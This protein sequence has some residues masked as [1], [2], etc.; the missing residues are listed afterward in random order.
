MLFNRKYAKKLKSPED[1]LNDIKRVDTIINDVL[2]EM[3]QYPQDSAPLV[4]SEP[5]PWDYLK[6]LCSDFEFFENHS[7]ATPIEP[8]SLIRNIKST[9]I[10]DLKMEVLRQLVS[11][12]SA[13]FFEVYHNFQLTPM[14]LL[15]IFAYPTNNCCPW[16]IKKLTAS[17]ISTHIR[18]L[19]EQDFYY[20]E[21]FIPNKCLLPEQTQLYSPRRNTTG[22]NPV[23]DIFNMDNSISKYP[24]YDGGFNICLE[25]GELNNP[26]E[27]TKIALSSL[28]NWNPKDDVSVGLKLVKECSS[29]AGY[30]MLQVDSED[31]FT[32]LV[33]FYICQVYQILF[34][35]TKSILPM[36]LSF[37]KSLESELLHHIDKEDLST[38]TR[39]IIRYFKAPYLWTQYVRALLIED[40]DIDKHLLEVIEYHKHEDTIPSAKAACIVLI[41]DIQRC[42]K[43]KK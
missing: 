2:K 42:F 4:A 39:N 38:I 24:Y 10:Y 17:V 19:L 7:L 33:D 41:D 6:S 37:L 20:D 43:Q 13:Y 1:R 22:E 30:S 14:T 27:H 29:L 5:T 36:E 12:H 31:A 28:F 32:C 11:L 35:S 34:S 16:E 40:S 26:G 23:N 8:E 21:K 9:E 3:S 15:M 18:S 25:K